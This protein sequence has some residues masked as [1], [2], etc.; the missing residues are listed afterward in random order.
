MQKTG[1]GKSRKGGSLAVLLRSFAEQFSESSVTMLANGMVY[2]TLIAVVPC[3]ALI[4]TVLN[5]F[6]MLDPVIT[7]FEGSLL[8]IFGEVTGATLVGYLRVFTQ[9]A[10]GMGV[11][12]ILSFALTFVLHVDKL[13]IV[14]NR[15][16]HTRDTG[17]LVL[18]YLKYLLIIVAGLISLVAIIFA[19]GRFSRVFVKLNGLPVLSTFQ[20]VLSRL[21]P[22]ASIFFLLLVVTYFIPS[23]KV[24]M[25]SALLGSAV[26]TVLVIGLS[27]V[28]RIIV[29]FSVK[30]SVIYGSLAALLFFFLY[31]SYVWK[32][33]LS[34]V[35]LSYVH[36]CAS[37]GVEYRI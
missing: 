17:N 26:S 34:G 16:F 9:N 25:G 29:A 27:Y 12:S 19:V 7:L 28:F 8:E 32:I 22:I 33:V 13:F 6:G 11:I 31:L 20:K 35:V 4:Y 30:Y 1:N 2:S 24:R 10:M 36:Q 3:V 18:R 37:K 21:I 15:I 14:V 23:C 5:M